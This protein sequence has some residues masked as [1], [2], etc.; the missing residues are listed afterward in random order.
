MKFDFKDIFSIENP[1]AFY[2]RV[3]SYHTSDPL[4]FMYVFVHLAKEPQNY[5]AI[6]FNYVRY[7]AGPMIW[8]GAN[9][10]LAPYDDG[11]VILRHISGYE[12]YPDEEQAM[13]SGMIPRNQH[14]KMYLSGSNGLEV[15]I[16]ALA[17]NILQADEI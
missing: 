8:T 1:D 17:A 16:I 4:S 11:V 2:C 7:F 15:K 9:F 12:A 10:Q 5:F 13:A 3:Q 14:Y 6:L